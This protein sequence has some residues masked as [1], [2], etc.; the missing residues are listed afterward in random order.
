DRL[1]EALARVPA[2]GQRD[3]DEHRIQ[4]VLPFRT[5][6]PRGSQLQLFRTASRSVRVIRGDGWARHWL[7]FG[8]RRPM[9]ERDPER[10][11]RR[12]VF[13]LATK[14]MPKPIREALWL[15]RSLQ[16][17]GFRQR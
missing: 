2:P 16:G 7:R 11:A 15:L 6:S 10:A 1:R 3:R 4:Q 12:A 14:V 9:W 17:Y 8:R 5:A 13:R